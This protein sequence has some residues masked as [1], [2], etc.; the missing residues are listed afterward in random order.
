VADKQVEQLTDNRVSRG[1]PAWS[2]DGTQIAFASERNDNPDIFVIDADGNNERQLTFR[3]H[4]DWKPSWS[5]DGTQLVF[6]A[7]SPTGGRPDIFLLTIATSEVGNITNAE[8][9][10]RYSPDWSRAVSVP[11]SV[12]PAHLKR[13]RWGE[14]KSGSTGKR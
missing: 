2:P 7:T 14:V 12:E 8:D 11:T 1:F 6:Y 9:L 13:V 5:P 10:A 4:L 3:S